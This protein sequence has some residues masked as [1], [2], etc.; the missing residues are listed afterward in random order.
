MFNKKLAI[1][2]ASGAVGRV[3]LELLDEMYPGNKNLFLVASKRSAGNSINCGKQEFIIEDIENFNFSKVDIAFFSAGAKTAEKYA[4]IA[5][6]QGCT[7]IDNSSQFRTD[8]EKLLIV[9]E[10]NAQDLKNFKS[11]GIISN[12]NCS[13]AQL[14]VALKPI[15]DLFQ[16]ERVDVASYQ[17]V[18]G[19]GKE[20]IDE[21]IEQTKNFLDNKQITP[22]V[23]A[24][25]N[26]LLF[27]RMMSMPLM[28]LTK[29][30]YPFSF[31]LL[32]TTSIID[33]K[34]RN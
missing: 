31:L 4:P 30:L 9:P 22:K 23:Y 15:D 11:P 14:E 16:I 5:V 28:F 21:L 19:T 27:S 12:P 10:V 20:G 34:I 32:K 8:V 3:F 17:S 18:S 25:K 29:I 13:T 2:G 6:S 26:A 33:K 1:I 7:V 24:N